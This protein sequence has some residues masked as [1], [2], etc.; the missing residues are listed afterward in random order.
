ME[1]D[2]VLEVLGGYGTY[3]ML[4]YFLVCLVCMRGA[5]HPLASV[6]I[7]AT[8]PHYC[9]SPP[10]NSS[11]LWNSS[12]LDDGSQCHLGSNFTNTSSTG[13]KCLD[14]WIYDLKHMGSTIVSEVIK[15]RKYV[16]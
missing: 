3:Q 13:G 12:Q 14:G 10:E 16:L 7:S 2:T 8:P 1:L 9:R 15:T 4:V 6:F 11:Y 5:W